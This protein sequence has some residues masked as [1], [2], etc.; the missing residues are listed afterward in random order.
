MHAIRGSQGHA[1]QKKKKLWGCILLLNCTITDK[2]TY[3][4][5]TFKYFN[6]LLCQNVCVCDGGKD[7]ERG[8]AP[9]PLCF[10]LP[11]RHHLCYDRHK[12]ELKNLFNL[13]KNQE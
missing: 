1:P 2:I 10:L 3:I 7:G 13:F 4:L 9:Q 8:M 12:S 5:A 6:L 11:H